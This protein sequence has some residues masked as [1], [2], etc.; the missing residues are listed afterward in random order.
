[1]NAA[2]RRGACPGLSTPM[3]TGDGLLARL[4]PTGKVPLAAFIA[5]CEAAQRHGNGAIELSARGSIQV[6]GLTPRSA[7]DFAGTVA[8]LD[9]AADG[10]PVIADPLAGEPAALIDADALAAQVRRAIAAAQFVLSPKVSVVI[11]G[12]GALHL[13][14]LAADIRLRAIETPDGPRLHLAVAGDAAM[15]V[16]LG[17]IA[18]KDAPGVVAP[19]LHTIAARGRLRAADVSRHDGIE[20]FRASIA[21]RLEDAM[22]PPLRPQA[23]P[24]GRHAL[25]SSLFALGI[26]LAFGHAQA[27]TLV[28]L[29][30]R[31]AAHGAQWIRPAPGR[32]LLLGALTTDRLDAVT[33]DAGRLGFVVAAD[34]PRRRIAA[35][36]GAPSCASGHIAARALAAN[37]AERVATYKVADIHISGCA[38]GCAHPGPAALTAVGTP[39]GCDIV[40]DGNARAPAHARIGRA[41]LAAAIV[42]YAA[43]RDGGRHG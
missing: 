14:A 41:D 13:D 20:A 30:R 22:P 29:A 10:V 9:L 32:A 42:R 40:Y 3:P 18:P 7:P 1:M 21:A 37:I 25:R 8:G 4:R 27:A 43:A 16:P 11:D 38:K 12:G 26:G 31:A 17:L 23:E 36:P 6:R 2:F 33:S 5:F 28:E 34:D 19:L 15:A 24:V 39:Q 35:C